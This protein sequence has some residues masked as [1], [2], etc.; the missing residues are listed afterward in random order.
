MSE[1]T[2]SAGEDESDYSEIEDEPRLKYRR[3][4]NDVVAVL[5]NAQITA[6]KSNER[7]I[8]LGTSD[9]QVRLFDHEVGH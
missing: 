6:F 1:E 5:R 7:L 9:G 8:A 3:L 2:S 4:G